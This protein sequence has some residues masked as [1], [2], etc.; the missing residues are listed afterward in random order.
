MEAM[1]GD[2]AAEAPGMAKA[3]PGL[4]VVAGPIL[5]GTINTVMMM[6][7]GYLAKRRCRSF[8]AWDRKAMRSAVH[9]VFKSVAQQTAGISK[10][11]INQV[12]GFVLPYVNSAVSA[13]AT[14]AGVGAGA[15]MDIAGAGADALMGGGKN[16]WQMLQGLIA[17]GTDQP[18]KDASQRQGG[19]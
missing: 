2:L 7:V 5:D 15:A 6:R 16:L 1:V 3:I 12:G 10:E 4:S 14:A 19:V 13:A 18:E 11:L 9:D 8:E 17:G